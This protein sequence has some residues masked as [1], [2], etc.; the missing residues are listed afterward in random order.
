MVV[1]PICSAQELTVCRLMI[2]KIGEIVE[3]VGIVEVVEIVKI[4]GKGE[5]WRQSTKIWNRREGFVW[6]VKTWAAW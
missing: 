4:V 3:I 6:R 5:R 2:V 1:E